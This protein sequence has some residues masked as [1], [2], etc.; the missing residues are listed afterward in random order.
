MFC[1]EPGAAKNSAEAAIPIKVAKP[2]IDQMSLSSR[3]TASHLFFGCVLDRVE[4]VGFETE[5][6][7]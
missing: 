6:V 1:A 3:R 2:F 7:P 4:P 5:Q